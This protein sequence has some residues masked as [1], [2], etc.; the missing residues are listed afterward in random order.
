MEKLEYCD[1][2]NR[3]KKP[4][5]D[6]KNEKKKIKCMNYDVCNTIVRSEGPHHRLCDICRKKGGQTAHHIGW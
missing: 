4:E 3:Y 2:E 1:S 5:V 6:N